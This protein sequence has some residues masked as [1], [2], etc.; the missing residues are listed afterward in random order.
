[1]DDDHEEYLVNVQISVDNQADALTAEHL[2]RDY[3]AQHLQFHLGAELDEHTTSSV[4]KLL[5]I[6]KRRIV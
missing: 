3:I 6:T 4:H 2:I 5:R 1:M